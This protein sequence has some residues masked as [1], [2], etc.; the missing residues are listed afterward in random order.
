MLTVT[1]CAESLARRLDGD[2][3]VSVLTLVNRAGT[4]LADMHT[5]SWLVRPAA[6]LNLT[7]GS[8]YINLPDDF[9][10]IYGQP[11]P[12]TVA[13]V[14]SLEL[15]SME[16]YLRYRQDYM[17][18]G[19]H[20][21]ATVVYAAGIDSR[22]G[23]KL[24]I[25]PEPLT[26]TR[27]AFR[28]AYLARWVDITTD[29]EVIPIPAWLE[30]LYLEVLFAVAQSYEEHDQASLSM[31][32]SELHMSPEFDTAKRRDGGV[33]PFIGRVRGGAME[34]EYM[35][36]SGVHIGLAGRVLPPS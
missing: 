28:M 35:R 1:D 14:V 11:K 2:P 7:A 36:E 6:K 13:S 15:V 19:P 23:P 16:E 9:G 22:F 21:M 3:S 5:W 8:E 4:Y 12:T 17:D 24:Q 30:M 18:G 25:W 34:S 31:R 32:L 29:T 27:D 10:R 26:T 33:Q 20:Y